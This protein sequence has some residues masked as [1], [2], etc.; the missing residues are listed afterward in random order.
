M[1]DVETIIIGAILSQKNSVSLPRD[2]EFNEI[3]TIV[4]KY[5]RSH[6]EVFWFS[7]QYK[8]N[9]NTSTLSFKYNFSHRKKAFFA[10]EINKA[11][12]YLFQPDRLS[13]LYELEKVKYVYKWIASNTTYNE[14]SSFNQTIYS[15]LINRNSVCTGYAKTAQYLLGLLNVES[16]LVFGKFHSDESQSGR[17]CW[18]IVKI[19][20]MWYHVDFCMADLALRYLLNPDER[21]VERDGLLWNYFCT[22]SDYILRNRSI[23]FIESY[24]ECNVSIGI[25]LT[26][27]LLQPLKQ[28]AVC[29][30]DSGS[31]AK[32]YLDSFEKDTVIKISRVYQTIISNELNFLRKLDGCK[33]IIQCK[34]QIEDGILLEQ[35]TPWSELLNSHY[36]HPNESQLRDILIQLTE[37]LIECRNKG[38]TY[39]DIHYNN[40][41]VSK[42]GIYKWGDFG[43]AY[44][45]T[46]NDKLPPQMFGHDGIALGGR[47]FMSPETFH[48]GIYNESSTIYSLAMLAYYVMNDM[49]PPFWEHRNSEKSLEEYL[50]FTSSIPQP[51]HRYNELWDFLNKNCLNSDVSKRFQTLQSFKEALSL[52]CLKSDESDILLSLKR[53][54]LK[55]KLIENSNESICNVRVNESCN[56]IHL[57]KSRIAGSSSLCG[58]ISDMESDGHPDSD[59]F[60]TTNYHILETDHFASTIDGRWGDGGILDT[61]SF[62]YTAAFP[63]N[64]LYRHSEPINSYQPQKKFPIKKIK[65]EPKRN[66]RN[67]WQKLDKKAYT[68]VEYDYGDDIYACLYAPAQIQPLKTFI[69]RVYLYKL[70]ESEI[71]D[72]KVRDI[73]PKAQ[74][75]EY[76]PLDF[77]IKAGD[78][79]TVQLKMSD[80]VIL[81]NDTKTIIWQNH[82]TDCSFLAKL[83]DS[84]V[85]D[86]FGTAYISINGIPA[87]ELLFTADVVDAQV[88]TLYAKVESRRYSR[89]FISYSHA[90]EVQVR[91]FAEC[92]RAL[93]T[94]YFFDRH[95][96]QAGDVFKE[97]I[98]DY[99]NN[100]DLFVLCWSKNAA[101]SEWVQIEREHALSLIKEGKG[102]LNIYPLILK[103]EAPLPDDMSDK[104]NFAT[105]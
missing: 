12:E 101:E 78:K 17:H 74:K 22:S 82:F 62:A 50:K 96:L 26:V 44:S 47:W 79:L 67:F 46:S 31:S 100:A 27:P 99:I 66:F 88:K 21:P 105:L 65:K 70:E 1:K 94:D 93:G 2:T 57:P 38:I 8:W 6:P 95:T 55:A 4:R 91:G 83:R 49:R 64:S 40:V 29:K 7:H 20:G 60:A 13:H 89:I 97:K 45:S 75:K 24:P 68:E 15:V 104:Y 92:C 28:L 19:D 11:V 56:A 77:P 98:L 87:G 9:K 36:Y 73:D 54:Q 58:D 32:V 43:I 35:L 76:K 103:P 14:Y 53:R 69:V 102:K 86:V 81:D 85:D 71:V 48:S 5:M 10:K 80:G 23:E 63:R 18:N 51:S 3:K 52:I 33:H 59:D 37:G 16:Q 41:F 84:S 34:G 25:K 42:D 61:D 72:T 90:D 30:S 39:S